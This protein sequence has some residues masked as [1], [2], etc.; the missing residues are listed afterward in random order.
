VA[1]FYLNEQ[2]ESASVGESVSIEG[3]ELRV[4]VTRV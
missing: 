1:H 3:M 2:L 4:G